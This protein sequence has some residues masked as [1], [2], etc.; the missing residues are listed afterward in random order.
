MS[1]GEGLI[2]LL[3][4][5]P[6]LRAGL[7]AILAAE[8]GC[9]CAYYPCRIQELGNLVR[10][11]ISCRNAAAV[12]HIELAPERM[13]PRMQTAWLR[14][15][16]PGPAM[17]DASLDDCVRLFWNPLNGVFDA[18]QRNAVVYAEEGAGPGG[19]CVIEIDAESILTAS[20]V[21]WT[22]TAG[23]NAASPLNSYDADGL[24]DDHR[25]NWVDWPAV[26]AVDA[27]DEARARYLR[28]AELVVR[29]PAA[30]P[31]LHEPLPPALVCRVIC[32]PEMAEPARE[33][34]AAMAIPV[35]TA[36]IFRP[37][38]ELFAPEAELAESLALAGADDPR[39]VP[40]FCDGL[41]AIVR[42]EA[43]AGPIT[44]EQFGSRRMAYGQHGIGHA[45]R[46]MLWSAILTLYESPH[47]GEADL[48][49]AMTAA[50]CHDLSKLADMEDVAH[51]A[52]SAARFGKF[53]RLIVA[54]DRLEQ[55]CLRAIALHDVADADVPGEAR[56]ALWRTLKDA[57]GLDRGR[58]GPPTTSVSRGSWI[59]CDTV[60][61]R[62]PRL[63]PQGDP[64]G[65][66]A[67]SAY[68]LARVTSCGL[69]DAAP[70]LTFVRV[71]G[72]G[73][74]A[75]RLAGLTDSDPVL[76]ETALQIERAAL[77]AL[78]P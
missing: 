55:D 44:P 18:L 28:E 27:T 62:M 4:S 47:A 63:D 35:E 25:F 72:A 75:A 17:T 30:R 67:W 11:G 58:F 68:R 1:S 56:T 66:V 39:I 32:A 74:R 60:Q 3:K 21:W 22:V 37:A 19:I 26:Y 23:R 7:A 64:A 15:N 33:Q 14:R 40:C 70:N 50:R 36:S 71:L 45:V 16:R 34:V 8:H 2:S 61:L 76:R 73:M 9:V 31:G 29:M 41:R 59:A 77:G 65:H 78:G 69:W 52:R 43:I 6:E 42:Y 54:D 53:V 57:D 46:V 24:P 51:G 20:E 12:S 49:A 13:R 10:H 48:C 5:Q 38:S